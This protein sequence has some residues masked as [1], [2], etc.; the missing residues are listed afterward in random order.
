M[1][2]SCAVLKPSGLRKENDVEIHAQA[3]RMGR[4]L[5][6]GEALVLCNIGDEVFPQLKLVQ[7]REHEHK[8]THE[9][10][11]GAPTR[12]HESAGVSRSAVE[13]PDLHD[14]AQQKVLEQLAE[15]LDGA[16][17]EGKTKRLILVA[18]ARALG[19]IRRAYTPAIRGAMKEEIEKDWVKMPIFEIE[20]RL[21][22]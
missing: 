7:E 4:Y 18:P 14:R 3:R 12:V 15:S 22:A 1:T 21:T 5:R 9:L 13:Q 2:K 17:K 19:M 20:K 11:R 8:R 10:G 6:W 16:L